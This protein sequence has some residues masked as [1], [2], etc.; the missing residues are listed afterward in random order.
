MLNLLFEPISANTFIKGSSTTPLVP[1]SAIA[2]ENN[3]AFLPGE[4]ID[5]Q[6]NYATVIELPNYSSSGTTANQLTSIAVTGTTSY[7]TGAAAS[8]STGVIG[9]CVLFCGTTG[10]A[11]I[12]REGVVSC[13]FDGS[14]TGGDFVQASST[15]GECHDTGSATYPT[16]GS[17]VLGRVLNGGSGAHS[18]AMMFYPVETQPV[19]CPTCVTSSAALT[20]NDLVIG[21]GGQAS[22]TSPLFSVNTGSAELLL[23]KASTTGT[24]GIYG[25][26]GGPYTLSTNSAA[27]SLTTSGNVIVGPTGTQDTLT[28]NTAGSAGITL[29]PQSS[30]GNTITLPAYTDTMA[31]IGTAQ[32]FSAAQTFSNGVTANNLT[33]SGT[34]SHIQTNP[35]SG[36]SDIAG[37]ATITSGTKTIT[38]TFA[39]SYASKPVCVVTPEADGTANFKLWY[40]TIAINSGHYPNLVINTDGNAGASGVVFDYICMGNP[41]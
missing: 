16:N 27:T 25:S 7:A 21:A 1:T 33:F 37:T 40:V 30:S 11:Q 36:Q 20:G 13:S 29:S 6:Q 14:A 9:I 31:V 38:V 17:Q 22:Q 18:Y 8:A 15:A 12:A 32:T 2:T 5:L 34:S 19:A 39:T 10:T 3:S 35:S 23:G 41:N 26:S 24:L 28:L 4:N